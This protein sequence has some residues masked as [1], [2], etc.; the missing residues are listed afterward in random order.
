MNRQQKDTLIHMDCTLRDGGYYNLWDFPSDL[1]E[2]YLEAMAAISI[3]YVELG[4]R[5]LS[6]QG[7]RGACAYTTDIFIQQFEIPESLKISVMVNAGELLSH[8][9]GIAG[10]LSK[11]FDDSEK[12]PVTL[13]RLACH[14]DELEAIEEGCF[15]LKEKGYNVGINLMQI[16]DHSQEDIESAGRLLG[17][18]PLDVLYFADSMGEM[19][20]TRTAEVIALL[21][22][23]WKGALG[24]HTHD[25][26]GYALANSLQAIEQGVTWVDSTV[27]GM[28]RGAG[29][30]KTEFLAIE[31]AQ[32][33]A[34]SFNI[35]P[36]LK[37]VSNYF[38]QMQAK[39]GWGTNIYYYLTGKFGIH[40]TYVQEMLND[41]RF[42]L[43]DI[44]AVIEHLNEVGGSKFDAKTIETGRHFFKGEVGGTWTPSSLISGREVL[45][46][47]SGEGVGRY[48]TEIESYVSQTKPIVI[49]LNTQSAIRAELIDIRAA[50]HPFRLLTDAEKYLSLPQPLVTPA[51]MLPDS[52]LNTLSD[53]SLLDFGLVVKEGEFAFNASDCVIS[54][55]LVIAYALAIS[56]SGD[57]KR[58][59]LTGF[60]GYETGD[61]RN[62]EMDEMLANFLS[63]D[64][65]PPVIAITPSKYKVPASSIYALN[66][67]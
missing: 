48:R 18:Y 34:S 35:N 2:D 65:A 22:H 45:I 51:S 44:M 17:Q 5:F 67:F 28:G 52:I 3:D 16:G 59:L 20:P 39:Y 38:N 10:A 13:V 19:D 53:H 23:S 24:I 4:F 15:W 64:G 43:E 29:N 36:L 32:I 6:D 46:V 63:S 8:T 31:V 40:P 25:N 30:A 7:F 37:L 12:S 42:S 62:D 56:A 21:R 9:E 33:R 47:G 66:R 57:A 49:A 50:C 61:P 1:I 26:M 41:V 60:D 54:T 27:T 55:S 11:L 14:F 58:I